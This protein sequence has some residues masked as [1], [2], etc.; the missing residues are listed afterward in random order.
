[1]NTHHSSRTDRPIRFYQ[2][3]ELRPFSPQLPAY[4]AYSLMLVELRSQSRSV[5]AMSR[6]LKNDVRLRLARAAASIELQNIYDHVAFG[7]R[8][9]RIPIRLPLRKRVHAAGL[10]SFAGNVP[11]E[12]RL[13]P[14]YGHAKKIRRWWKPSD[15]G[16]TPPSM[17][18]EILLHELAH[19]HQAYFTGFSD[20]QEGFVES[21]Y[22]IESIM[23]GFGPLLPRELRFCGCPPASEAAKLQG[24]PRPSEPVAHPQPIYDLELSRYDTIG[25]FQNGEHS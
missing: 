20:H 11:R 5:G 2:Q 9:P 12:I 21:Y 19:I 24:S 6:A 16:I 8:L 4:T 3:D 17:I 1:V 14:I 25:R 13:F 7:L 10:A 15:L 22:A 23:L 18:C